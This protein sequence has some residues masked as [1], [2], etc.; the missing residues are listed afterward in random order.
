MIPFSRKNI[1]QKQLSKEKK[2]SNYD[3][4]TQQKDYFFGCLLLQGF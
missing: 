3:I 4:I 2:T 1:L